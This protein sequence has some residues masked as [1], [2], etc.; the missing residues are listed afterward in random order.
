[1]KKVNRINKFDFTTLNG[2]K[3]VAFGVL[4]IEHQKENSELY[5]EIVE[6]YNHDLG[7]DFDLAYATRQIP[8]EELYLCKDVATGNIFTVDCQSLDWQL[9]QEV[10]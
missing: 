10:A 9:E 4:V 8:D 2:R 3:A 6:F 7:C 1:M 5:N